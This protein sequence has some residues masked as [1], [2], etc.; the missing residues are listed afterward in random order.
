[1]TDMK[2]GF[3]SIKLIL[4]GKTAWTLVCVARDIAAKAVER[5][6]WL[7]MGRVNNQKRLRYNI[8]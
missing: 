8:D 7:H 1:M 6:K 5:G 4:L 2:I 3:T